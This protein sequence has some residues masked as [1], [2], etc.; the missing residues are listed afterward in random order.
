[1]KATELINKLQEL[2]DKHGDLNVGVYSTAWNSYDS[3][4]LV[5]LK[6]DSYELSYLWFQHNNPELGDRFFSID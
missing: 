2:V 5:D 6:T 3:C 4:D 1:M